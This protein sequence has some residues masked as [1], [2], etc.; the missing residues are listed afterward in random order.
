MACL[1]KKQVKSGL[2]LDVRL[3]VPGVGQSQGIGGN[4]VALFPQLR[5][6]A[7]DSQG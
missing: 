2:Q 7:G 6:A 3:A 4:G 1:E 5:H